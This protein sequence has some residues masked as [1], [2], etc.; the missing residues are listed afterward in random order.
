MITISQ[1]QKASSIKEAWELNQ[2]RTGSIIG[3]MGWMKM[4]TA[5]VATAIDICD[6]GLDKIEENEDEFILGAMVSLRDM[7]LHEGL[8]AYFENAFK[9][10][11]R[12]IVGV[13]FR[14]CA[15]IGGTVW[16]RPGFSD[17]I[18][19]LLALDTYVELYCGE[20]ENKLIP[21]DEFCSMK[22]DNSVIVSIRIKKD[23][24]KVVYKSFRNTATDFPVLAVAVAKC[25]QKYIAS[26]GARPFLAKT[27]TGGDTDELVNKAKELKYQD[28]LRGTSEYR[29]M[30]AELLINKAVQEIK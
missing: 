18:T 8:N 15:T 20:D 9:E 13:Q 30:L 27:V 12:H 17:P 25:D 11:V 21:L 4:T 19:L 7:E 6:L 23:G 29:K 26:V 5:N 28:N 16:L 24:R 1:Y 10:S 2:K 3:G 22:K 14:N